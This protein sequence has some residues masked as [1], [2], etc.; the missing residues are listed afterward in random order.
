MKQPVP[1]YRL[2]RRR[3]Q[4]RIILRVE[5]DGQVK[6]SAPPNTAT[7]TIDAFVVSKAA[8]IA[9]RTALL[10]EMEPALVPG[11]QADALRAHMR[12][13]VAR[14]MPLWCA[15]MGV[16]TLPKVT[17]KIM[18]SRWGSCNAVRHTISLN[19]E[20]ARRGTDALEYVIV[21]ELAHVFEQNHGP[22]FYALMDR[23]LP[24]WKQRRAHLNTLQR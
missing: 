5:G 23:H 24:D 8:W 12:S 14:L 19:L 22:A 9:E 3:G 2:T 18:K 7:R 6:V 16:E 10:A 4:R 17:I 1:E 15:R 21:H 20:L 11:P 13:D